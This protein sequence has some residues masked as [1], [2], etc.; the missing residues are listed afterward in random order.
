MLL[1]IIE[2]SHLKYSRCSYYPSL[3]NV[4]TCT[5]GS[6][7]AMALVCLCDNI[8]A[9]C[10]NIYLCPM[11]TLRINV[12]TFDNNSSCEINTGTRTPYSLT[13]FS[14]FYG[15]KILLLWFVCRYYPK[16]AA[17]KLQ[18]VYFLP[19]PHT[20]F[21]P[22]CRTLGVQESLYRCALGH[23]G[24]HVN[25]HT[26]WFYL[27]VYSVRCTPFCGICAWNPINERHLF[28]SA[29]FSRGNT[30]Q[31][32][33]I[34]S[35]WSTKILYFRDQS[36]QKLCLRFQ[37]KV[38]AIKL[39]FRL[40]KVMCLGICHLILFAVVVADVVVGGGANWVALL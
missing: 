24:K 25:T 35:S 34:G 12:R 32:T 7:D 13:A 37:Q 30:Y 14:T 1:F 15:I 17:L 27:C 22:L 18:F 29:N 2:A 8:L 33:L 28:A 16:S 3:I 6:V 9:L 38:I 5:F 21:F 11:S 26:N 40:S 10:L 20:V 39:S 19:T 31:K 36:G 4:Y 23:F